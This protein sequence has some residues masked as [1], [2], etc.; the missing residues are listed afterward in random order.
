MKWSMKDSSFDAKTVISLGLTE[1]GKPS[2]EI[3]ELAAHLHKMMLT[4]VSMDDLRI[5]PLY[6]PTM[7]AIS[8]GMAYQRALTNGLTPP[9]FEEE[10][11][12][13]GQQ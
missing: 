7:M 3:E 10:E 8:F 5:M 1:I 9:T 6:S 13:N 12:G 4:G 2:P 11:E